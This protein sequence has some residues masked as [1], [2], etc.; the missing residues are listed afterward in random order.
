[1][2]RLFLMLLTVAF[3]SSP[4]VYAEDD[5]NGSGNGDGE[6]PQTPPLTDNPVPVPLWPGAPLP[7]IN[8][9]GIDPKPRIPSPI[10]GVYANGVVD[11]IFAAD[12]GSVTVT[13]TSTATGT[14][15]TEDADSC[16]G[17]V[18]VNI[19][20]ALGSYVVN[21]DTETAGSFIGQFTL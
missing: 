6:I 17:V 11:I 20:R 9:P 16:D 3:I 21:I 1:M 19:G 13:V 5:N 15:W 4:Y 8:K 7:P 2:K 14:M 10:S 18:S 12:L